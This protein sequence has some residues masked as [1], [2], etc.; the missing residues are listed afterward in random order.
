MRLILSHYTVR[1]CNNCSILQI[2]YYTHFFVVVYLFVFILVTFHV[3]CFFVF[4]PPVCCTEIAALFCG[5]LFCFVKSLHLT[6]THPLL[7]D[8]LVIVSKLAFVGKPF[9][10]VVSSN[11]GP[12]AVCAFFW[13]RIVCKVIP[14]LHRYRSAP[15]RSPEWLFTL[16]GSLNLHVIFQV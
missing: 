14:Y 16:F 8:Y 13:T 2:G 7:W 9:W 15:L 6:L 11:N 10:T 3:F 1:Y 4:L 12:T 5:H